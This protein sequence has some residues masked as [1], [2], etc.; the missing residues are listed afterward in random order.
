MTISDLGRL[1]HYSDDLVVAGVDAVG[2]L[3]DFHAVDFGGVDGDGGAAEVRDAA[4]SILP[5]R[6]HMSD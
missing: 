6:G 4:S 3:A 2:A 1:F 5:P